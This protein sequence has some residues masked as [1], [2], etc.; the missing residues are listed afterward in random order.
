MCLS[1]VTCP[2]PVARLNE[3][4]VI[5][6]VISPDDRA[7]KTKGQA[8]ELIK[9]TPTTIY[10]VCLPPLYSSP[11][12]LYHDDRTPPSYRSTKRITID[13]SFASLIDGFSSGSKRSLCTILTISTDTSLLFSIFR[14]REITARSVNRIIEGIRG[15]SF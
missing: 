14:C 9:N 5:K 11:V 13:V 4:R 12:S 15:I 10:T 3:S 1:R 8:Y 7:N 2:S 6:K